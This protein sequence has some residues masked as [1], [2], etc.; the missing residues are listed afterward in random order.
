[1]LEAAKTDIA[2]ASRARMLDPMFAATA[3]TASALT[4]LA[5]ATARPTPGEKMIGDGL[6]RVIS[7]DGKVRCLQQPNASAI[8]DIPVPVTAVPT[9]CPN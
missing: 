3:P 6:V 5:R 2:N 1:M 4:P 7:A 8:R 9:N